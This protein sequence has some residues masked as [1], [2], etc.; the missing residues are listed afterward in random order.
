MFAVSIAGTS[1][2]WSTLLTEVVDDAQYNVFTL[3]VQK[4]VW[5]CYGLSNLQCKALVQIVLF[6][7][8]K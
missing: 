3:Y 6:G 2:S 4:F 8:S 5:A 1:Q 7:G